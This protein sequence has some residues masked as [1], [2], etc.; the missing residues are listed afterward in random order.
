MN[1]IILDWL[2]LYA[3]TSYWIWGGFSFLIGACFGSFAT[4]CVWR[5]PRGI[6][7]LWPPSSCPKC[8]RRISALEN[9]PILS[10]LFLRGKCYGCGLP[11]S[12]RYLLIELASALLF[13]AAGVLSASY[14]TPV[15]A[16]AGWTLIFLCISS[17]GTDCEL[18][19]IPDLFTYPTMLAGC[20]WAF[21]FPFSQIS[22]EWFVRDGSPWISLILTLAMTSAVGLFGVCAVYAGRILFKRDAL[23]W[24]DVKFL[25]AVTALTNVFGALLVIGFGSLFALA[26]CLY[27]YFRRGRKRFRRSFAFGPFLALAAVLYYFS[28]FLIPG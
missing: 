10:W 27:D 14:G 28:R 2:F 1:Q 7:M 20:L 13:L 4:A 21:L 6:S 11:I 3:P 16:F 15:S 22:M 17:T 18:R 12:P 9:I 5:V 25:M 19:V 26:W 8:K 24:G 23:G